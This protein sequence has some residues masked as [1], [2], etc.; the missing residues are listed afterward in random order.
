MQ[1]TLGKKSLWKLHFIFCIQI[2]SQ[3]INVVN[4]KNVKLN[5][6]WEIVYLRLEAT[7]TAIVC[8]W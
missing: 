5:K 3:I 2:K 6:Y 4:A 7:Y 8:L 1:S